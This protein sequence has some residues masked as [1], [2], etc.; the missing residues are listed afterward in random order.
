MISSMNAIGGRL[1]G[2]TI[3]LSASVPTVRRAEQYRRIE[4]AHFEIEQ[5]VISL[6]RAVFSES[7]QLVFGGH[8]AISPLVA[9]IAGEYRE[10]RYA[11]GSEEKPSAPIRIFQSRAFEG[12]LPSDTLLMYQ[13]GYATITWID[14]AKN[15]KFD[16]NIDYKEPPCPESLRIMREAMIGGTRPE[17]MVCIGGMEGVERE[18]E[19]FREFRAESPIYVLERTGGAS[20]LMAHRRTDVRVID[21]EIIGRVDRM[22]R[23]LTA[24]PPQVISP[25]NDELPV[26]PYPLV[27][28]TIVDEVSQRVGHAGLRHR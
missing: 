9:M 14:A 23:E 28:Q 10:P 18:A 13:L 12:F 20:L 17:A 3:F 8:P 26:V 6:A 4:D 16:P 2:M 15:E 5:A 19:I 11:E 7:G 25:Q 24:H 22:K 27:M 21:T 1:K